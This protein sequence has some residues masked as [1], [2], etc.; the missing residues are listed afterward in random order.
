MI[1]SD[2][3]LEIFERFRVDRNLPKFKAGSS[4]LGSVGEVAVTGSWVGV[5]NSTT[6]FVSLTSS[7]TSVFATP[8]IVIQ[9]Q[10]P[11]RVV[12]TVVNESVKA[13]EKKTKKGRLKKWLGGK[14]V[15][16]DEVTMTVAEFFGAVKGQS[17]SLDVVAERAAGY[18]KAMLAAKENGQTAL[19]EILTKGLFAVRA[20]TQ[21][22]ALGLKQF[23]DEEKLVEF[24]KKSE[25]GLRLDWIANFIRMI[26]S[27]LIEKKRKADE[28]GIFD[29]YVVLHY[30]PQGKHRAD[31]E[32]EIAKKKDPILFGVIEN[33]RRLYFIGDWVD[34]FCDLTLDK[35]AD[36]LGKQAVSEVPKEI[37]VK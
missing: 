14:E 1:T 35:I 20:E 3:K 10:N 30:D 36:V 13:L 16:K 37:E 23:L 21:L 4:G 24:V 31:T 7:A 12:S 6:G 33:K 17:G 5:D 11:D 25:R 2:G 9:S 18:E 29:N 8:T 15:T 22:L 34:E 27:S 26:P 32:E 19:L 28:Q